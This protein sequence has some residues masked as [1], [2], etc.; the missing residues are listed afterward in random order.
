MGKSGQKVQSSSYKI[1]PENVV[2]S[3]VS[4]V[5]NPTIYI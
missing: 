2:Y 4:T 3:M 5:N 1:S